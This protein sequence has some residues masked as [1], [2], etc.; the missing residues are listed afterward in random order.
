MSVWKEQEE[1]E[2]NKNASRKDERVKGVK[3]KAW[4]CPK[5]ECWELG[6]PVRGSSTGSSYCSSLPNCGHGKYR[7]T[8]VRFQNFSR[9][10][11]NLD[12]YKTSSNF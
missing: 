3:G 5:R 2:K 11:R 6:Q 8:V 9:K 1:K 12:S 10:A 4:T 7:S